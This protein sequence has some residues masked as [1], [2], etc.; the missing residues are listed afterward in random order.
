MTDVYPY[1]LLAENPLT[2]TIIVWLD[3]TGQSDGSAQSLTFWPTGSPSEST[4]LDATGD[5]MKDTSNTYRFLVKPSGLSPDTAYSAEI[6]RD[7]GDNITDLTFETL[8]DDS[9]KILFFSDSHANQDWGGELK[10][11]SQMEPLADE[12]PDICLIGGDQITFG[13]RD[14]EVPDERHEGVEGG[15]TADDWLYWIGE[16]IGTLNQNK[17]VPL[18]HTPGNH[19]IGNSVWTGDPDTETLPDPDVGWF[20]FLFPNLRDLE[21]DGLNYG[22]ISCGN[23][24]QIVSIDT[25]SEYPDTIGPWLQDEF[26]ESVAWQLPIHHS[27]L[28][29]AGERTDD[30]LELQA[31]LRDFIAGPLQEAPNAPVHFCGHIHVRSRSVP[32]AISDEPLINSL[33]IGE[34]GYIVEAIEGGM[35]EIGQGYRDNRPLVDDRYID[36]TFREQQYY[37]VEITQDGFVVNEHDEDGDIYRTDSYEQDQETRLITDQSTILRNA[38]LRSTTF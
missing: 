28:F 5:L 20:Q 32:W 12:T 26:D 36:Y 14:D 19:D 34:D 6:D 30:D 8:N 23:L 13:E 1:A 21:P 4:T 24:I 16:M 27:P 7:E 18:F 22:S 9:I 10:F 35:T 25:H 17:L 38:T 2:E 31:R 15:D 33:D 11:P 3:D 29:G 37:T